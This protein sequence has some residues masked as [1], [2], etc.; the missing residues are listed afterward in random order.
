MSA[1]FGPCGTKSAPN[2]FSMGC[3]PISATI[4]AGPITMRD[5]ASAGTKALLLM[6]TARYFSPALNRRRYRLLTLCCQEPHAIVCFASLERWAERKNDATCRQAFPDRAASS[7]RPVGHRAEVGYLARGFRAHHLSRH[8][9]PAIDWRAD[10]RRGGR[11]LHDE[12]RFRPSA[13]D[14]HA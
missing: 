10:R 3:L 13:T 8:C 4:S 12:G 7:R 14:V 9:R 2:A 6:S 1:R 5:G 11:R